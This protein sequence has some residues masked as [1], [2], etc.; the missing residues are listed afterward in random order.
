MRKEIEDA[1]AAILNDKADSIDVMMSIIRSV[2]T[3]QEANKIREAYI[4]NIETSKPDNFEGSLLGVANSN[5]GY[6][7]GYMS[8]IDA[9]RVL[10]LFDVVHPYFGRKHVTGELTVEGALRMGMKI[11][12]RD[13][14]QAANALSMDE[15]PEN[16]RVN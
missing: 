12:L 15:P 8:A 9:G 1:I 4:A 2:E 6:L 13:P 11:A 10:D 5:I 3:K 16:V 7:T 14:E